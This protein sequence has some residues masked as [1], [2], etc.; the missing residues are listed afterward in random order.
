MYLLFALWPIL[1]GVLGYFLIPLVRDAVNNPANPLP[2][3]I[4]TFLILMTG[5]VFGA[6]TAFTI[7]DD[8]DDNVLMS[9]KITPINVR[10]YIIA[11]LIFAYIFGVIATLVLV[12]TTGFLK[13]ATFIHIFLIAFVGSLQGPAVALIVNSFAKNK[14]EGFVFMKLSG[15]ILM[16]PI[17]AFWIMS[18]KE[19]ILAI[20]PGFWPTRMVQMELLPGL[21]YNMTFIVYFFIGVAYNLIFL[22]ILMKIYTK[23]NNI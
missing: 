2:E 15:L 19:L 6:V 9:L 22:T 3:V 12:F 1:F 23:R 11:K 16:L 10:Y 21:D 13:D 4:S 8:N 20:A 7:L 18:W 14:V 5:F 17:A